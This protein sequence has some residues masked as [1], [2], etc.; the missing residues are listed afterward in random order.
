MLRQR[1][2]MQLKDEDLL[3]IDEMK[4]SSVFTRY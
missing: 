4:L 3:M 1:Q 2:D